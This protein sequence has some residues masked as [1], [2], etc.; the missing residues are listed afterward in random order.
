MS[1]V[2]DDDDCFFLLITLIQSEWSFGTYSD[3]D[4][5]ARDIRL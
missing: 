5:V 2:C 3:A 4:T 1:D